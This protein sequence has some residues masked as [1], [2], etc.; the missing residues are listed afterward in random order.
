MGCPCGDLL[1]PLPMGRVAGVVD[2]AQNKDVIRPL[3]IEH[4]V[5]KAPE[6]GP[7][8]VLVELGKA[9]RVLPDQR[10]DPV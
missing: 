3:D 4:P 10:E 9:G 7:P 8:D 5:R 6:V 1:A 2:Y